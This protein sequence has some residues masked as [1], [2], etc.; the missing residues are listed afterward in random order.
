M[1]RSG[2]SVKIGFCST[3]LMQPAPLTQ[4][5]PL[6]VTVLT[7]CRYGDTAFPEPADGVPQQIHVLPASA[8]NASCH[9][10]PAASV[11]RSKRRDLTSFRLTAPQAE[12]GENMCCVARKGCRVLRAES[13]RSKKTSGGPCAE[14]ARR[15]TV[16][17]SQLCLVDC[18][19]GV[20]LLLR[21]LGD[22]SRD[23]AVPGSTR[24]YGPLQFEPGHGDNDKC[25]GTDP[26]E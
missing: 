7:T 6:D 9:F 20:H 26:W 19:Q 18:R 10:H 12:G 8:P 15:L 5:N 21:G 25:V 16:L 24:P 17:L 1:S 2:N 4:D 3:C 14:H 22:G 11:S 13:L 23:G